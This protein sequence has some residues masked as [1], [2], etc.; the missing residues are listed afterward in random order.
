MK[1][2]NIGIVG[3]EK[4]YA[5]FFNHAKNSKSIYKIKFIHKSNIDK[6]N[7]REI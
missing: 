4:K 5:K 3:Y 1:N 6:K 2:I 7:L